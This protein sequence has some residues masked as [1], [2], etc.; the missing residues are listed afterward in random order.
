MRSFAS[1]N[2]SGLTNTLATTWSAERFARRASS[3]WPSWSAP[4]VGTN[5][6]VSPFARHGRPW[7]PAA[8]GDAVTLS[9]IALVVAR[10]AP[11]LDV[12]DELLQPFAR[13]VAERRVTA[14]ELRGL[15]EPESHDVVPH[16]HLAV[17]V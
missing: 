6:T 13:A 2:W 14:H 11:V 4:I 7:A 12:V 8:R 16:Q 10:E 3:M 17:R 9:A 15:A 1:L 5:A